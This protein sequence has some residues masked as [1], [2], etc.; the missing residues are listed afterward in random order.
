MKAL[1][2]KRAVQLLFVPLIVL[3][4]FGTASA[5]KQSSSIK[6]NLSEAVTFAVN[7]VA[8]VAIADPVIADVVVLSETE[9]SIIGKKPGVTTLTIT[10][11]GSLPT[12]SYRIEVGNTSFATVLRA[13]IG[14][15][16]ITVKEVGDT[17]ILD[18]QVQDELQL[19]RVLQVADACKIKIVNLLEVKK[20]RQIS[21]RTRVAEVNSD[22]AR[23]IGLKWLGTAGQAEYAMGFIGANNS[24]MDI[25][26]GFVPPKENVGTVVDTVKNNTASLEVLLQLLV[27]NNYARLLA[28]PT[29]L[30]KSGSEASFLVGE[31]RPIVQ[32]LPTSVTVDYKK[33][34]VQMKIK[35]TADSQNRITTTIHAE[36]SQVT[37]LTPQLE[38]PI[39]G[40]KT[41][42]STL[43]VNDGQTIIIGGLLENNLSRDALR[44]VPWLADIPLF[45]YLFRHREK[46]VQQREVLFFMTPSIVKDVDAATA[47][48]ARSPLMQQWN[49][50]QPRKDVLEVPKPDEPTLKFKAPPSDPEPLPAPKKAPSTNFAP[51]RSGGR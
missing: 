25:I 27:E 12:E 45:G 20:P 31:E 17:I 22:I 40:T 33:I 4:C 39:I 41:A 21:I 46:S 51:A 10:H 1:D 30:T 15:P 48:A 42:D 2:R 26:H 14:E 7:N 37:G 34:G 16:S 44:K 38:I 3:W 29:L 8:K 36:V 47:G 19:N 49:R 11:P 28:E 6:V 35:P 50:E 5:A 9:I 24:I 43:Q 18:G 32:Q 13:M 23:K